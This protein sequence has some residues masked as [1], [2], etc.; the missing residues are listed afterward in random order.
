M[1]PR[2][3]YDDAAWEK[4]EEISD[5]WVRK[6]LNPDISIPIGKF[7]VRHHN[8]DNAV[9]FDIL[10]KGSFNIALWMTYKVGPAGIIRF[11]LPGATMFP[12]EKQRCEVAIMRYLCD[13][14]SIRVPFV[15]HWGSKESCPLE[16]GSYIIMEYIEHDSSMYDV[17]NIPGCLKNQRGMLNP[18]IDED[19]LQA[20]YKEMASVLLRLS[21]PSFPHIG[22]FSQV[23]DFTWEVAS[24]PLSNNMN[25]LLRVGSLPQSCLPSQDKTFESTSAYLESIAELYMS[26]LKHQRNDAIHSADDCRRKFMARVLF[27]QLAQNRQLTQRWAAFDKGPFKIW[28]DDFR[29]GNV[30]VNKDKRIAGIVDF[31]F[32][33]AA[34]IEFSYAPPWW[35]LIEKPEYWLNGL[36]DWTNVFDRRLR[37][38]IK[39]MIECEDTA[40]KEGRLKED[41]RLSGPMQ[42]SWESGDFWISYAARNAF[43]FDLLYWKKID[44]RFFGS[45]I[46]DTEDAWKQR[47][48]LLSDKE[49]DEMEKLVVQKLEEMETRVLAWDPDEHTKSHI[50]IAKTCAAETAK[51]AEDEAGD[52]AADTELPKPD[53]DEVQIASVTEVRPDDLDTQQISEKLAQL[54]TQL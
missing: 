34:P 24:R 12:E 10:E 14:T 33:Y 52:E 23:D 11:P 53:H 29:P 51:K 20:L 45:T 36:D 38:F 18:D 54:S 1:R 27:R 7:L 6:F 39:G 40:I 22:S 41:E 4:S 28:C 15:Y 3:C 42:E 35:L 16:L 26:H 17:L 19:T 8:P 30:L 47:L 44:Q 46:G 43:A 21:R 9:A 49:K 50:D 13:Q 25:E 2:M 32:T 48:D 37:T 31:E 5:T